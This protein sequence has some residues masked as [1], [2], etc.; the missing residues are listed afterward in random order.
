MNAWIN[1]FI[2]LLLYAKHIEHK[3]DANKKGSNIYWELMTKEGYFGLECYSDGEWNHRGVNWHI[4][5]SN[6]DSIDLI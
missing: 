2:K 5:S 3:R 1:K 4:L 6:I